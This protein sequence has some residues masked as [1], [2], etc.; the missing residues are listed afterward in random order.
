[1]SVVDD[2]AGNGALKEKVEAEG[3]LSRGF[4][5]DAGVRPPWDSAIM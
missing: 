5:G 3:T 1:M 2:D 4:S